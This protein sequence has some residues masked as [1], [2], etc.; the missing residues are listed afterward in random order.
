MPSPGD[1]LI[2]D[3]AGRLPRG[4]NGPLTAG[5]IPWGNGKFSYESLSAAARVGHVQISAKTVHMT[6]A[7][8]DGTSTDV[9]LDPSKAYAVTSATLTTAERLLRDLYAARVTS[10]FAGQWV[11][12]SV[13][14]ERKNDSLDS[15]APTSEQWTIHVRQHRDAVVE[16]LQRAPGAGYH[17]RVRVACHGVVQPVHQLL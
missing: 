16:Q 11:P 12:S 7:H 4:V 1:R 5:V 8:N 17:G 3:A 9:T 10:P 14:V 15:K 6:I 13:T 2:V